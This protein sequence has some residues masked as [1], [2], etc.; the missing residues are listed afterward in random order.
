MLYDKIMQALIL[1]GQSPRHHE[2]VRQVADALQPSY[3]RVAFLDYRHWGAGGDIDVAHE[4]DAAAKL[5]VGLGDYVIVAKSIGSV[6]TA[7]GIMGGQL[8]PKRCVFLGFPLSVV[9]QSYPQVVDAFTTLPPTVFV[10]NEHDPLG[11]AQAVRQYVTEARAPAAQFVV[12]PG[13][14]HDYLDFLQIQ[15]LAVGER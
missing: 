4:V 13:E 3:E 8:A 6:V 11:S 10:Q 9:R 7:Y 15:K 14:T 1:G 2:W 5:A 12:T